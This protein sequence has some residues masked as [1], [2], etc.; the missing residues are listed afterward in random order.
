ML[1]TTICHDIERDRSA[2]CCTYQ[3]TQDGEKI[4]ELGES[5]FGKELERSTVRS[6]DDGANNGATNKEIA[7]AATSKSLEI[8]R[9]ERAEN[10]SER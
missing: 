6:A 10:E 5:R 9:Q 8:L 2:R 4:C 3:K 7:R 1:K